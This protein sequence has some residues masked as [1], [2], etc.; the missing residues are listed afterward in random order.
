MLWMMREH[1]L[2]SSAS[3]YKA[4]NLGIAVKNLR[5]RFC[6]VIWRVRLRSWLDQRSMHHCFSLGERVKLPIA[7]TI[8][9]QDSGCAVD[10][11]AVWTGASHRFGVRGV[12][13][14]A[15]FIPFNHQ[16]G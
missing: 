10:Q 7:L 6:A 16:Q 15:Q 1:R 14:A 4:N 12:E 2:A 8:R 11:K 9:V 13:A 3:Y 5:I